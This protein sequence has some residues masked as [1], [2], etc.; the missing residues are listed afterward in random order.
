M[1]QYVFVISII[2]STIYYCIIDFFLG[3]MVTRRFFKKFQM[4][5]FCCCFCCYKQIA[6]SFL[7]LW[8][9]NVAYPTS[10]LSN[11]LRWSSFPTIWLVL[12]KCSIISQKDLFSVEENSSRGPGEIRIQVQKHQSRELGNTSHVP[13]VARSVWAAWNLSLMG[14]SQ[15]QARLL[16]WGPSRLLGGIR[17][18]KAP[19]KR[20][21]SGMWAG[22]GIRL[23]SG[24]CSLEQVLPDAGAQER[25][26]ALEFR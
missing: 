7:A 24:N 9:G 15:M 8:L 18:I 16:G 17:S 1:H 2:F 25:W 5:E 4:A 10:I 21:A 13:C 12:G 23:W 6:C 11:L 22:L 26:C 3:P 14:S 19:Y 20:T